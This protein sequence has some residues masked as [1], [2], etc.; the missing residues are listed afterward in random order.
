MMGLEKCFM[1]LYVSCRT[2]EERG[3]NT[4]DQILLLCSRE[5]LPRD[6][7]IVEACTHMYLLTERLYKKSR[8]RRQYV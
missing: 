7:L 2:D 1:K 3:N 4:T 8:Q 6:M 5:H